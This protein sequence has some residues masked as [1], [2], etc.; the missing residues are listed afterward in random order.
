M[1]NK[2]T[3]LAIIFGLITILAWVFPAIEIKIKIL[4]L[5]L[6]F[7]SVGLIYF[8]EKLSY[9][10]RKNWQEILSSVLILIFLIIFYTAFFELLLPA[11]IIILIGITISLLITFKYKQAQVF[12]FKNLVRKV[13]FYEPWKLNHWQ[14]NCAKIENET[15]I[16]EGLTAP[17]GSDGSHIDLNNILEIGN[18][19]EIVC[20]AKSVQNTSGLFQLWCHDNTGEKIHGSNTSTPYKT[21]SSKGDVIRLL[22]RADYN[23]NIRIHLQ[24]TPGSGRIIISDVRIYKFGY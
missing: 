2:E 18:T 12:K 17:K 21:P 14:S 16:F 8:K 10:F 3:L 1:K 19:Y 7:L 15:M 23:N 24:Y 4:I 11:S 22:F 9:F 5:I 6:A 20:N 13:L